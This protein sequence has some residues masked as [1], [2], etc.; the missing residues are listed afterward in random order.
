MVSS[1]VSGVEE[2]R[3][4]C[5]AMAVPMSLLGLPEAHRTASDGIVCDKF[6]TV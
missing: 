5:V 2:Y 3:L 6:E 1:A 4:A